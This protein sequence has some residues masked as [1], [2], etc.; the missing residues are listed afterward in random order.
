MGRPCSTH[1]PAVPAPYGWGA[2]PHTY[3]TPATQTD[4]HGQPLKL[5][6]PA[7]AVCAAWGARAVYQYEGDGPQRPHGDIIDSIDPMPTLQQGRQHT[8]KDTQ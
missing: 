1:T 4:L 6:S 2:M 7:A 5:R 8:H 3:S